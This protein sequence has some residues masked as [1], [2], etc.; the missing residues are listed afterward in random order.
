MR[1]RHAQLYDELLS[2]V[3]VKT[4][5]K[6][7]HATHVYHLYVIHCDRRDDLIRHLKAKGVHAGIHYPVPIH[8]QKAYLDLAYSNGAF[9]LTERYAREIVSL[10]MFP[11][12]T[13]E[14]IQYVVS[15]IKEFLDIR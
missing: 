9:P 10:P 3:D 8:L 6:R 11:E 13:D 4:P 12:L 5:V 7:D 2:E 14:Q 15:E 1:G